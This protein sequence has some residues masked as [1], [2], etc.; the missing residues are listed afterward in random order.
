ML[1]RIYGNTGAD[2]F[3]INIQSITKVRTKRLLVESKDNLRRPDSHRVNRII[4]SLNQLRFSHKPVYRN[5]E[6]M[7]VL[8]RQPKDTQSTF[9]KPLN[10]LRVRVSKKPLDCELS[11]LD[12]Y[13]CCIVNL[14]E[15]YRPTICWGNNDSRIF[16]RSAGACT[17]LESTVE[18]LVESILGVSCY[19]Y[20]L[21]ACI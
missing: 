6:P 9:F 17:R 4:L 1:Y 12:P 8:R 7:V 18:K 10:I 14:V 13:F 16:R 21:V 2:V 15:Y 3:T 11:A 19:L 5:M 20:G